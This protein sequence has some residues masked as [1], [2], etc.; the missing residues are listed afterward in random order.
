MGNR[1]AAIGWAQMVN[2]SVHILRTAAL[3]IGLAASGGTAASAQTAPTIDT[4]DATLGS[5]DT[6]SNGRLHPMLGFDL[7]NGD[8]A[9]GDYDDDPT[10]LARL[11]LHVQIGVAV[12]LLHDPT[13]KA[14]GWLVLRTSNG[15]HAPIAG[16]RMSPRGWYESN[17]LA[18]IVVTPAQGLRT[19]AVYT[20][21]TSPNGVSATTHEA[22]LSLAYDGNDAIGA[23]APT[24]AVTIRPKGNHGIFTLAGAELS[25]ALSGDERGTKLSLPLAVGIGWKDFYGEGSG[26]RKYM[27]AGAAFEQPFMLGT[28]WT[29][30]IEAIALL[31]DGKLALLS[32]PEGET[33]RLVPLVTLSVSLAY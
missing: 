22:S 26:T 15:F 14:D 19:A 20:I 8:F 10:D 6:A 4:E 17:T 2:D 28:Q 3:A 7:R 27:S 16:Q 24:F 21:K 25:F 30:R 33:N 13:G 29:A 12:D 32:G 23:L 1:A 11:P 9:R 5:A 18:A 31:R